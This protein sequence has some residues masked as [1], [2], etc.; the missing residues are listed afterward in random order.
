M[1]AGEGGTRFSR[2][3]AQ[4]ARSVERT[5]GMHARENAEAEA[6]SGRLLEVQSKAP[7]RAATASSQRRNGHLMRGALI[8]HPRG[9]LRLLCRHSQLTRAGTYPAATV[10]T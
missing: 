8:R 7:K 2:A 5:G 10:R 4:G 6:A 1:R 9:L 3:E